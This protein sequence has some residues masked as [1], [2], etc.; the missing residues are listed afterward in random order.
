MTVI[1]YLSVNLTLT[2]ITCDILR[3][4]AGVGAATSC[5]MQA[6]R[7]GTTLTPRSGIFDALE[8]KR[9]IF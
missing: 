8:R 9:F 1:V 7:R 2:T 5:V 3:S 6:R 4:V